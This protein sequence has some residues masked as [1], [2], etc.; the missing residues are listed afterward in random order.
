[1]GRL[2]LWEVGFRGCGSVDRLTIMPELSQFMLGSKM[3]T[4][5]MLVLVAI[6]CKSETL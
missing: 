5:G 2:V 1:M 6:C 3:S 4:R